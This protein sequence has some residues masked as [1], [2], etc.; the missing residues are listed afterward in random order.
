MRLVFTSPSRRTQLHRNR[1]AGVRLVVPTQKLRPTVLV[2]QATEDAHWNDPP[3]PVDRSMDWGVFVQRQVS[4][5]FVVIRD[6]AGDDAAEVNLA[7]HDEMVEWTCFGKA[8]PGSGRVGS[9]RRG[10]TG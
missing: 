10:S 4:P 1:Q 5:S 8:S 9:A 2:V 6:V 7:E 3:D